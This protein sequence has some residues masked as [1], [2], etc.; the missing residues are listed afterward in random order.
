MIRRK[1]LNGLAIK[2]VK[3]MTEKFHAVFKGKTFFKAEE[4]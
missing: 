1:K 4:C 3:I 2:Y